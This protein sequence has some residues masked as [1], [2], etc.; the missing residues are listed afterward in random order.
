[1]FVNVADVKQQVVKTLKYPFIFPVI[2][3]QLD[4]L[5]CTALFTASYKVYIPCSPSM[6]YM[7]TP[8]AYRLDV[9]LAVESLVCNV[10]IKVVL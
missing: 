5:L 1:M 4:L 8:V 6:G 7:K 10:K 9:L 2:K 3:A